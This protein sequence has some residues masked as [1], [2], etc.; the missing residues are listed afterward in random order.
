MIILI[1]GYAASGK[2]FVSRYIGKKLNYK[3]IHT[4]DILKQFVE[5]K[6]N[7]SQK[8]YMNKGWYEKSRF[9]NIRNKDFSFDKKLY[10]YLLSLVK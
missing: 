9:M 7:I 6:E 4:S 8:T 2:S 10:K 1:C 5:K 3:V